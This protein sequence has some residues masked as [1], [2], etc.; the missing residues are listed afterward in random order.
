MRITVDIDAKSLRAVQKLTGKSKKSPAV[1][2]AVERCLREARKKDL[3]RRVMEGRTDYS[4]TN[5]ELERRS[6]YDHD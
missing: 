1:H 2:E 3:I 4:A 5:E 6:S